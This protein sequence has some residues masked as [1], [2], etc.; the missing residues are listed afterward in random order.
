MAIS[1]LLA[2]FTKAF[3]AIFIAI[4]A[5]GNLPILFA[6][7]KKLSAKERNSHVN[8]A[9]L[10]ASLLLLVF[11]FFGA[12]FLE[13]FSIS[14]GSFRIGGGI[15]LLIIGLRVV[16]GLRLMEETGKKYE[17]AAVPL[18]TPMITGPAVITVIIL[19]VGEYGYLLTFIA[20]VLNLLVAWVILRQTEFLY[21]VLGQQ[22]SDVVARI[23]GLILVALAVEFI[24]QGWYSV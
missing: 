10:I 9:I 6:L 16:L 12:S 14:M 8:K 19:L 4:D 11:L 23:M 22:G 17:L 2:D 13:Y 1:I 20:S 3:F 15:I 7:T 24:K 21:R 18:A 5:L